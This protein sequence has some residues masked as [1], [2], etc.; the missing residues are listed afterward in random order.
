MGNEYHTFQ[1]PY[2]IALSPYVKHAT[3]TDPI[4]GTGIAYFYMTKTEFVFIC[5]PTFF[6]HPDFIGKNR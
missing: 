1:D 5:N 6:F 3:G 4:L 2:Y